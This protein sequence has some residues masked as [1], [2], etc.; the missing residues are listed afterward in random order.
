MASTFDEN[1]LLD[2][3]GGDIEFLAETVGML[4]SD[5]PT[6][7]QQ[8]RDALAAGDAATVGKAAH[9]LKGMV[10]N[11]CAPQAQAAALEVEKM[12][13]AG[14]LSAAPTAV[15]TLATLVDGL[16]AELVAFI[17]EKQ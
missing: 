15:T 17:K 9:T 8:I 12:G 14:D 4:Q 11:F 10:S 1:A 16:T 3:V 6:L 5:G 7:L 13:K 2:N